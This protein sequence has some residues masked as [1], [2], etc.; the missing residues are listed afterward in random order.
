MSTKLTQH[1]KSDKDSVC[2][3]FISYDKSRRRPLVCL[4]CG[5][6]VSCSALWDTEAVFLGSVEVTCSHDAQQSVQRS[7]VSVYRSRGAQRG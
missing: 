2:S 5:P 7:S 3:E 1:L 4:R 6:G